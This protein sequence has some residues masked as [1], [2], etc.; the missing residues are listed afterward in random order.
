MKICKYCK[1]H[2][3]QSIAGWGIDEDLITGEETYFHVEC[4]EMNGGILIEA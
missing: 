2:I 3:M 1:R 4:A